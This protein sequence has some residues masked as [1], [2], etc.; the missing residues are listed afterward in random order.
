MTPSSPI[1]AATP[2][3]GNW[4]RDRFAI[5]TRPI[6]LEE[7]NTRELVEIADVEIL[8]AI[9]ERSGRRWEFVWGGNRLSAPVLDEQFY[10]DFFA[11]RITIAPGDALRVKLRIVQRKAPDIGVFINES[12]EV[13]EVLKHLPRPKQ[14]PLSDKM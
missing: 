8:R 10:N 12:F 14:I 2:R 4:A 6:E 1:R 11:H 3:G 7:P 13:I 9:L 5:L